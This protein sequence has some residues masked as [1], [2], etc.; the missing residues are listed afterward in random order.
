MCLHGCCHASTCICLFM[1]Q[2]T[3]ISQLHKRAEGITPQHNRLV[4]DL[5]PSFRQAQYKLS[6]SQQAS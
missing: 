1:P 4:N 6:G 3:P 2:I 5:Y